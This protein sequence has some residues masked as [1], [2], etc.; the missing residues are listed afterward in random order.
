VRRLSGAVSRTSFVVPSSPRPA[1]FPPPPPPL[2]KISIVRRFTGSTQP[3][4]SSPLPRQLR[5]LGFL[6]W[7]GT[8]S[9]IA[10]ET[11]S[12]RFQRSPFRR[13]VVSDPGRASAP[14]L[15]VP[16]MLPSTSTT[17]SASALLRISWLVS[18]PRR[19]AVY[20][21]WPPSPTAHA[22]LATGRPATTLPGPD[23]HRLD[24]ASSSGAP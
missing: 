19:I 9:A 14:R 12:P 15:S 18:T 7:P 22:T 5:L 10:G 4:D 11:K 23:F 16:H 17:V 21:S 2:T 13:D 3:S 20:A 8:A 1:A 6:P 24:S